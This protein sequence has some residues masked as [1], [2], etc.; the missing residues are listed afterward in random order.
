M[1]IFS[2]EQWRALMTG[3]YY[4]AECGSEMKFTDEW[5]DHLICPKC[6]YEVDAEM[7]GFTDE[8]YDALYPILEDDPA[9]NAIDYEE[10]YEIAEPEE[11]SEE[12]SE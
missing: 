12:E 8:E 10:L 4:C 9:E 11:E 3:K 5:E 7:Y 1:S 2:E 6:G